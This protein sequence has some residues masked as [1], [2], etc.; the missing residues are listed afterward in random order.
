MG[1]NVGAKAPERSRMGRLLFVGVV[2]LF[3]IALS[4]PVLYG[5]GAY[6]MRRAVNMPIGPG[7]PVSFTVP[8]GATGQEV[9]ALLA[10]AG[11]VRHELLFRLA[12]RLD[13]DGGTIKHGVHRVPRGASPMA[14]AQALKRNPEPRLDPDAYRVTIPEGLTIRQIADRVEDGESFLAAVKAIDPMEALGIEAPSLEGFLMPNTYYFAEPPTG[15][16]LVRVM[17]DQFRHE[18]AALR[19]AH[20][21]LPYDMLEIVTIAS[22]VEEEAR[23]DEE[24]PLIAA[25]IENRLER[26]RALQFDSTLQYALDKYGQRLLHKDKEI[27]SP[28]NTYKYPGLPPGPIS[29]PGVASLRAALD[30]AEVEYLYF[31]SNAD[32][33]T[34]TFSRTL[35]EH[36]AA[37]AKYR[38]EIRKQRRE[39]REA[40]AGDN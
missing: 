21:H 26:G 32:G 13:E 10:D 27:D 40:V 39:L 28:Y 19:Q 36:E 35:R 22:L 18:Y 14:I 2:T 24:R 6:L 16:E 29:N 5:A 38:Q 23:V 34:H 3:V 9:A 4:V 15:D 8:E 25:V 31:V 1:E 12:M 33:T 17:L 37:V 7:D 30:P 11:L 20:P